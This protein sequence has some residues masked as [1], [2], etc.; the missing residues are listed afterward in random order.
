VEQAGRLAPLDIP[1]DS[2]IAEQTHVV[3]F[4]SNIVGAEFNFYG[5]RLSRLASYLV[6]KAHDQ[7]PELAFEILLRQDIRDRLRRLQDI[8]LLNLRIK[9]SFAEIVAQAD[10]D[11]GSCFKAAAR[12]A[13][14]DEVELILRPAPRSGRA[15]NHSLLVAVRRLSTKQEL[16]QEATRFLVKG[17]DSE[18]GHVEELDLLSDDLVVKKPVTLQNDRFR[19]VDSASAYQAI[20]QAYTE[21]SD[22]LS[23]AMGMET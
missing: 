19:S 10:K 15:L 20:E 5:P 18:T 7:C 3:F 4:P 8:R 12:A 13:N 14:A 11:L 1:D 2:G 22:D 6:A 17:L 16:H 23:Q 21:L 9:P